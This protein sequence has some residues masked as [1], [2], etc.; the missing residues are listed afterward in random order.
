MSR[1]PP[2]SLQPPSAS[3]KDNICNQ[4]SMDSTKM[5]LA[6]DAEALGA[7]EKVKVLDSP[8]HQPVAISVNQRHLLEGDSNRQGEDWSWTLGENYHTAQWVKQKQKYRSTWPW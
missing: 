1:S 2:F 7:K 4:A 5:H 3:K 8:Q 6:T